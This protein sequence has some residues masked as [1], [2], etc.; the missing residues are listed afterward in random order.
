MPAAKR[1]IVRE[2]LEGEVTLTP[3]ELMMEKSLAEAA[4][5]EPLE[6]PIDYYN[7]WSPYERFRLPGTTSIVRFMAG[8]YQ[9]STRRQREG[10]RALLKSHLGS[11]S[12]DPDELSGH[13]KKKPWVCKN[14]GFTALNDVAVDIHRDL[15]F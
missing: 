7:P 10:V 1:A 12:I 13:D 11:A 14:C 2:V 4:D 5:D 6:E 3:G 9:V 15:G 8:R